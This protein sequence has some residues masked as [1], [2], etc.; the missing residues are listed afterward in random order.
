MEFGFTDMVGDKTVFKSGLQVATSITIYRKPSQLYSPAQF[1]LDSKHYYISHLRRNPS[2]GHL[3]DIFLDI[4]TLQPYPQ[5]HNGSRLAH[6]RRL[7]WL[8]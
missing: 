6:H 2:T 5:C 4:K 3:R 1:T 7:K 8:W